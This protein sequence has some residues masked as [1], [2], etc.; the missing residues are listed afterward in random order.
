MPNH[1]MVP[2]SVDG[3]SVQEDVYATLRGRICA[4]E[5]AP[6]TVM[7]ANEISGW[8]TRAMGKPVSRTPVREA[9]IRLAKEGLVDL[10]PQK[11]TAVSL[12]DL[13]RAREER[14]LRETLERA[15][16]EQFLQLAQPQDF[17]RL[18]Q[19]VQQQAEANERG[20]N[21]TYVE[22]DNAFHR[23]LFQVG[24]HPLCHEITVTFNGHYDRLRVMT[25]WDKNNVRGSIRQ[26]RELAACL[27]A[28][29]LEDAQQ[30]IGGHL[31]KLLTEETGLVAQYPTYF[32][33]ARG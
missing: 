28:G 4:L 26:H 22:L 15:N 6:G 20:D 29:R 3:A 31:S 14:F 32:S 18:R 33:P 9:F 30:V 17:A 19:L 5:L 16:L 23:V 13:A 25:T 2:V 27:E 11:G 10:M 12:I 7:S 1:Q 24:Q 21:L 8:M